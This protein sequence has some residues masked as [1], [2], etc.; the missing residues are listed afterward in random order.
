MFSPFQWK[1]DFAPQKGWWG[2]SAC[3]FCIKTV[4]DHHI[5]GPYRVA[6]EFANRAKY[7]VEPD[8]VAVIQPF[9][10]LK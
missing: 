9:W 6:L 8:E 10:P 4:S 2:I 7:Q 3:A 1:T 5:F